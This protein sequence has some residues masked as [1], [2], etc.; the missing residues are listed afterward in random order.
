M[1]DRTPY[2]AITR[3]I[4]VSVEPTYLE[5]NSSPVNS[6]YFWAYRVTIENQGRETVQLRSRHWMIS[7][8][9]G[10][11]TEVKG[12][13]VVGMQP[14]LK[15]GESYEYTSGAP[16]NTPSGMMGGSYQMESERGERFDIE[17]PTFSLDCPNQDVL[18]N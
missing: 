8:A 4:A 3:G 7:N 2:I 6:Q 13:G 12:P 15:P 1:A 10:E 18:L 17:I 9:R 14:L 16:L 11:L 5:A